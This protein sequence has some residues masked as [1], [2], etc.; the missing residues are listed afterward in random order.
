M[1]DICTEAELVTKF[2]IKFGMKEPAAADE[3]KE[4]LA[5]DREVAEDFGECSTD[6][7]IAM[8]RNLIRKM[9][10]AGDYNS[11]AGVW[12]TISNLEFNR[13]QK[14]QAQVVGAPSADVVRDRI[15]QLMNNPKVLES[16]AMVGVDFDGD[17]MTVNAQWKRRLA[18]A[19]EAKP[20]PLLDV[21]EP[22]KN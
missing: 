15:A 3:M 21:T 4:L 17:Q 1:G 19:T 12:R 18:S 8:G 2:S 11:A 5:D 14:I 7:L 22:K 10:A 6:R 16:A 20:L 13:P 9:E